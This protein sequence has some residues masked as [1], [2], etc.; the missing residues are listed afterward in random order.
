MHLLTGLMFLTVFLTQE[1]GGGMPEPPPPP[2]DCWKPVGS[3]HCADDSDFNDGTPRTRPNCHWN[4]DHSNFEGCV[5]LPE[6][7]IIRCPNDYAE[8]YADDPF[9]NEGL[10][11]VTD[12]TGKSTQGS[13]QKKCYIRYGCVCE[14][15]NLE[16]Y[17]QFTNG[18]C[19]T[20]SELF[21]SEPHDHYFY[22]TQPV[23]VGITCVVVPP[24][25]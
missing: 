2:P 22:R 4:P 23:P 3:V 16:L 21:G 9:V 1:P 6:E 13:N 11:Q 18:V 8:I 5:P 24:G 10:E 12:G 25:V 17:P 19:W 7:M 20:S 15:V 14:P